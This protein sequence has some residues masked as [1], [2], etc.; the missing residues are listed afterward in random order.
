MEDRIETLYERIRELK[1]RE[2]NGEEIR[3]HMEEQLMT[4]DTIDDIVHYINK[5]IEEENNG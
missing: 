4:W 1:S 3:W 2:A 5:K